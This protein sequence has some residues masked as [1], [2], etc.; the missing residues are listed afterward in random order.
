MAAIRVGASPD[1]ADEADGEVYEYA[2]R[3]LEQGDVGNELHALLAKRW[4][5][6]GVVELTAVIGYYAMVSLMLNAQAIPPLPGERPLSPVGDN[7][8]LT[9]LPQWQAKEA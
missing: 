6:A 3:L 1:F 4:G 5:E 9:A 2:R 8:G 7:T